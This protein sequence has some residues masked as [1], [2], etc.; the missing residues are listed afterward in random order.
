M[1]ALKEEIDREALWQAFSDETLLAD[2]RDFVAKE[3]RPEADRIDREDYYPT[4]I[5]RKLSRAGYTNYLIEKEYGGSG[6]TYADAASIFEEIA[7]A[8]AAVGISLITIFQAQTMLRKY[9]EESLKKKWLP[10]FGEGLLASYALT[11]ANHGSDIRTLDTK[12]WRDGD[13]WIIDGEKHFITSGSA[14]EFY[15]TLA[16]TDA[17][18]TVF[19]VPGDAPGVSIYDGENSATFG[20][21]N[22]PH[23]NVVYDKVRLPADH[24]VGTEGKGVRQAATVLNHSRTL[25]GAISN[26]VS[27]AAYEDALAFA[28]DRRAFDSRV[29]EFQ[30]IQWYFSEMLTEIDSARLL[31]FRAASALDEDHQVIRWGSEAKLKAGEVATQVAVKAA[32]ICGAYGITENAPFSRYL[33]DAKA[34]E[35]AGGSNEILKNTIGKFLMPVA[36]IEKKKPK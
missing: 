8:S 29:L 16:E 18:V 17:G 27:R 31:V 6:G 23:M 15:I 34:Y 21:R 24:M 35:V 9:G 33:R 22:G 32:Q 1:T 3:I 30:G 2:L 26:G 20:L 12:A 4:E 36:G 28:R 7:V 19:A 10:K 25:A 11:E 14:A 13:D 5:V